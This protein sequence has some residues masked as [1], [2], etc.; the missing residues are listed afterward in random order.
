MKSS[1]IHFYQ[2]NV[3]RVDA[4]FSC[5]FQFFQGI[6]EPL[7]EAAPQ[8]EVGGARARALGGRGAQRASP[9]LGSS[10]PRVTR[11]FDLFAPL[12]CLL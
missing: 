3:R 5:L 4:S 11:S 1:N 7:R 9:G 2:R 12:A 10:T 6:D 8:L